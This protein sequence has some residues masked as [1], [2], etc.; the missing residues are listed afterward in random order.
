MTDDEREFIRRL[1]SGEEQAWAALF[2]TINPALF[3]AIERQI[4]SHQVAEELY[5]DILM[6]L[7]RGIIKASEH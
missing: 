1:R 2:E 6:I 7:A 5:C 3:D 4:D